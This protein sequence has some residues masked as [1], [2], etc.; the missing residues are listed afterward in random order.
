MEDNTRNFTFIKTPF[1]TLLHCGN[2][3]IEDL[4]SRYHPILDVIYLDGNQTLIQFLKDQFLEIEFDERF[5]DYLDLDVP[6]L[7][8]VHNNHLSFMLTEQ[9][10]FSSSDGELVILA[11]GNYELIKQGDA[12][13]LGLQRYYFADYYGEEIKRIPIAAEQIKQWQM[14]GSEAIDKFVKQQRLQLWVYQP[15]WIAVAKA[16]VES[17]ACSIAMDGSDFYI[18]YCCVPAYDK[19]EALRKVIQYLESDF[20][21][22]EKIYEIKPFLETDYATKTESDISIIES[23]VTAFERQKIDSHCVTPYFMTSLLI[24]PNTIIISKWHCD[25]D[26]WS[27][28]INNIELCEFF[29]DSELCFKRLLELQ[30]VSAADWEEFNALCDMEDWPV[31]YLV[32]IDAKTR[33]EKLQKYFE[34]DWRYEVEQKADEVF[35]KVHMIGITDQMFEIQLKDFQA[36]RYQREGMEYIDGLVKRL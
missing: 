20:L 15:I 19:T 9:T 35:L 7:L 1:M 24:T 22:A 29:P 6:R 13:C 31:H 30:K 5:I 23:T 26:Y 16:K 33:F 2:P 10:I 8:K 18:Y 32:N 28:R 14:I 25:Y 27:K 36:A 4:Q 34:A 17:V 21:S 3:S 12:Y 11:E